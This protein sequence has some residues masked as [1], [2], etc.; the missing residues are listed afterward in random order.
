MI[1]K[2]YFKNAVWNN[3]SLGCLAETQTMYEYCYY[4]LLIF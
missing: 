2:K 4:R 3:P 1:Q